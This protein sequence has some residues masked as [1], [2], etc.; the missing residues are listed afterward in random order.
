L[1]A[2]KELHPSG[3]S[4]RCLVEDASLQPV[5]WFDMNTSAQTDFVRDFLIFDGRLSDKIILLTKPVN[6]QETRD[7]DA[8]L[9]QRIGARDRSAFAEFY[10]KYSAMLFSIASRIL[11]DAGEAEDVLQ[12]TFMQIW[13]KG[14]N[15]NPKLGKAS[16]WVAILVRNKSIDRIRASQRRMGLAREAGLEFAVIQEGDQTANGSVYGH[17]KAKLIQSAL[18]ELPPEQRRAIEM[19]FFS[20]LTQNEI[21]ET[22]QE[23]LGTIK[24]RIRRGLLHL[25][26]RLEDLP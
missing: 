24:A 3:G 4:R 8:E 20:G 16:S 11:S 5:N 7:E 9:L 6:E 19:A 18:V 26:D 14:G 15:F 10:D 22:L 12:E 25:R 23:P 21:S 17:E 13:E 2:A 1:D